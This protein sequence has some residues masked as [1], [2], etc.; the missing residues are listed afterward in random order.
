MA[1]AV[2]ARLSSSL[3]RFFTLGGLTLS[4][5]SVVVFPFKNSSDLSVAIKKSLLVITPVSYTHLTLP[6]K[7]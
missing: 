5:K 1:A 3:E 4:M 6:T 7:A 2:S